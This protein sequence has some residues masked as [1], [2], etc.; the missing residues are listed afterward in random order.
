MSKKANAPDPL[1]LTE[2]DLIS[3]RALQDSD[4][5]DFGYSAI[6]GRVAETILVL[7]P[8]LT[9]GLFGPWG[10]GKTSMYELLR[11]ELRTKERK[12]KLVYYDASTYGGEAL[13]RNFISHIAGELG[14]GADKHPEFHRGL[15]ESKRR[16]EL[17]FKAVKETLRPTALLFIGLYLG[18]L[19]LF[20]VLAGL[21]SVGTDENFFGQVGKSLPQLIAPTAIGGLVI[22]VASLLLKGASF[23]AEQSQPASDEAFARCFQDLVERGRKDGKF[24]R[25]VVFVDELDRC[26]SEDVV[27]TLTAIR[28]F[29]TQKHAVFVVAADRAALERALDEKL[30]QP[31]PVNEGDPYYSSTSS[32]FDK[33]FH[34]RVPLPPLR[35]PRLYE[36]AF[37]AVKGRDGYWASLRGGSDGNL[38]KVLY[39]LIP[40]HVRAPR[41]VKILL[42]SFVRSAAIAAHAGLD[43]KD[44]AREI[45]KLTVLDTEFPALGADVR[46]EPRLPD[47][48]LAPPPNPSERLSRL[49]GKHGAYQTGRGSRESDASL[50]EASDEQAEAEEP[51]DNVLAKTT[52]R[53]R[54][55]LVHAEHEQLRRYLIRTR[56]VKIGRDLLFLD[57]AGAAVGIDD[58]ELAETLDQAVDAPGDVVTAFRE[59]DAETRKLAVRVLGDMAEQE[60]AEERANVITALMGI[61]ELL[62]DDVESVAD[63][64]VGSVQAFA[65]DEELAP[66]HLVGALTLALSDPASRGF[67]SEILG[68]DRLLA[69]PNRLVAVSNLLPRIAPSNRAKV[70]DA[71]AGL[72]AEDRARFLRILQEVP[73]ETAVEMLRGS[74]PVYSAVVDYLGRDAEEPGEH[75]QFADEL[76]ELAEA[77]G[78]EGRPLRRSIQ[79]LLSREEICYS[80]LRAHAE[81]VFGE[82][83]N[84]VELDREVL[85]ILIRFDYREPDFWTGFLSEGGHGASDNGSTAVRVLSELVRG[86]RAASTE[87]VD[88]RTEAI[89]RVLPLAETAEGSEENGIAEAMDEVLEASAWWTDEAARQRQERL[90]EIGRSLAGLSPRIPEILAKDLSRPLSD[91]ST[92]TEETWRGLTRMADGLGADAMSVLTAMEPLGPGDPWPIWVTS[93]RT[94][95]AVAA[96]EADATAGEGIVSEESILAAASDR[97]AHGDDA[98]ANWL[99][100]QP[101]RSAV[102]EAIRTLDGRTPTTV[103]TAFEVWAEGS[104]EQER[105]TLAADLLDLKASDSVWVERLVQAGVDEAAL[106]QRIGESVR[107]ASRGDQREELMAALAH[108]KP[109][110]AAAQRTVADLILELVATGK[111]VDFKAATRAIPGLGQEHRS[112]T[113]LRQGF[114]DAAENHGY[115]LTERSARQLAEAGV[116]VSKKSVSKGVWGSVKDFFR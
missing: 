15:Y 72:V 47:L 68:D 85:L 81:E 73:V 74:S 84:P 14:Y 94:R 39:F 87:E 10:S 19:F 50:P 110:S 67:Q 105:T 46:V 95:L 23:D 91:P 92:F 3:N 64:I 29:L 20:C 32:F 45:A 6:A 43:W 86:L 58:P 30:P 104:N 111:Q 40:S 35:G 88:E 70:Y 99:R 102:M 101:S 116:K 16:T 22:A 8:P 41:R 89:G 4:A 113:R 34:D 21:T 53:E 51:T 76:F 93:A 11:R 55:A 25:L 52:K 96:R 42:N 7:Q 107:K 114:Q 97:S 100:L 49:L 65:R 109:V 79:N 69:D 33:V 27:T 1:P 78:Q 62:G 90:H 66:A 9:V 61:V 54:Q 28:T 5:D 80:P 115:R 2:A 26:S 37:E 18:F 31:T 48:L 75:D 44:R 60:F 98:V 71:I 13:K 63:E 38:R 17:D 36:W 82:F 12:A 24:K 83:E 106:V 108:L 57:P 59:R 77:R 112:A 103:L 56:E